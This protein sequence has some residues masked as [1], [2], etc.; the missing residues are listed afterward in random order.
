MRYLLDSSA[1]LAHYRQDTG[2]EQVQGLFEDHSAQLAVTGPS[3]VVLGQ[4]LAQ[5][6]A[7]SGAVR[8]VVTAYASLVNVVVP[9]DREISLAALDLLLAHR[10]PLS[11][12]ETL[13]A[14]AALSSAATLVHNSPSLAALR[15]EGLAQLALAKVI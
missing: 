10:G 15:V 2:W 7:G 14:A 4:Q 6:G 5:L 3:L 11:V 9:V 12:A 8:Q 13:S 1:L